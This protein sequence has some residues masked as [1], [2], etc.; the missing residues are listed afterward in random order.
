MVGRRAAGTV[1]LPLLVVGCSST[2]AAPIPVAQ[3]ISPPST[4]IT[5][6]TTPGSS[7]SSQLTVQN[8]VD[9][10]TMALSDGTNVQVEGLAPM[11]ECWAEMSA[12]FAAT[13]VLGKPVRVNRGSP[14]SPVK[15]EDGTDYALLAVGQGA[16][17][18]EAPSGVMLEAQTAAQQVPSGLWGSPC[19]GQDPKPT[20]PAPPPPPPPPA[21]KKP[22]VTPTTRFVFFFDCNEAKRAGAAPIR[23]DQPGYRLQ[24]DQ[25]QN[26]I[27]CE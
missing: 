14:A 9:G 3:P 6:T 15:L 25:N 2:H 17:R 22:P 12:Q 4:T 26:G 19:N 10:R 18:A 11:G 21:T 1:L 23:R 7:P 27:A 16:A 5:T 24:L 8:I 20:T 13:M